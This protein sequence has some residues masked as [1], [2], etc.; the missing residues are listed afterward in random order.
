MGY[1]DGFLVT[2]RQH[3]LFG[4]DK[5]TTSYSGGRVFKQHKKVAGRD[6]KI[7]KPARLHG[8]PMP[9]RLDL[10]QTARWAEC[11]S[12]VDHCRDAPQLRLDA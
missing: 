1:L 4:G 12:A 11:R 10:R 3:R 2:L 9:D 5:V 6:E 8:R 7:A